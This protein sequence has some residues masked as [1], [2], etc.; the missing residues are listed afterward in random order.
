VFSILSVP[1]ESAEFSEQMGTKFKFWYQ[2]PLFGLTLFKEG[3]PGTGENWAEKV[4]SHLAEL[5]GLPHATYEL[6]EWR[7]RQGVV[8][9]LFVPEGARL[10]HGNELVLGK[11]TVD[12]EDKNVRFYHERTHSA[13]RVFQYLKMNADNLRPPQQFQPFAGVE[14]ALAV[15]VGY[16]MFDVWIANQD[17]HSENWAIIRTADEMHLAPTYDHGS[18]LGRQET[19]ARRVMMMT[20][21]DAGAS[22]GAYV[23]KARSA[24]YPNAAGDVRTRA[25][26]SFE[27]FEQA[28]KMDPVAA[29]AWL[30]RLRMVTA[31]ATRLILNQVPSQLISGVACDFTERL[32]RLNQDRLLS[33][34][35]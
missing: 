29:R 20:T 7:G 11:V 32:L 13:S 30:E 18:S 14:T 12:N 25:Y 35:I 22:L 5:L 10:V 24:M 9:P 6:A 19:D 1:A 33:L 31:G 28:S 34:E 21:R 23:K 26:F 2:D 4:S 17:R 27:L 8:S 16:L 15:F 3:R